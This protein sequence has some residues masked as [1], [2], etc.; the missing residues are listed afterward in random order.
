MDHPLAAG[1][2]EVFQVKRMKHI[3]HIG[4]IGPTTLKDAA[5]TRLG[6]SR[7]KQPV[8]EGP[9]NETYLDAAVLEMNEVQAIDQKIAR[10]PLASAVI[11]NRTTRSAIG[12]LEQQFFLL[13][14]DFRRNG[15]DGFGEWLRHERRFRFRSIFDRKTL[16]GF[17][18]QS[19]GNWEMKAIALQQSVSR[20]TV[21][22]NRKLTTLLSARMQ[23]QKNKNR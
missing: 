11:A 13:R 15:R 10:D 3:G 8:F 7:Q 4:W 18:C 2:Q 17:H 16:R 20:A 6:E 1:D 19:P 12:S 5:E 23:Q 21:W 9:M 22:F 14:S